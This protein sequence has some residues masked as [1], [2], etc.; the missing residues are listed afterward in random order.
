VTRPTPARTV[1][2]AI[3]ARFNSPDAD[4]APL[5]KSPLIFAKAPPGDPI[6][7]FVPEPSG[8]P[9]AGYVR[10]EELTKAEEQNSGTLST[11]MRVGVH[12]LGRGVDHAEVAEEL[13][14][15]LYRTM[16]AVG[17]ELSSNTGM[18]GNAAQPRFGLADREG[19]CIVDL[20]PLVRL[21]AARPVA[22]EDGN[23]LYFVG[24][25]WFELE[26]ELDIRGGQ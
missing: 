16:Q 5:S 2:E 6:E 19:D 24:S 20:N 18:T 11:L 13:N 8:W 14:D 22:G 15:I 21:E 25:Y 7:N 10:I 23:T 17:N 9:Y 4:I 1:V 26:H 3:L 12:V